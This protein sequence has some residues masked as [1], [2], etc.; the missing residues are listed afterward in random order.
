MLIGLIRTI[1]III[2]IYYLV[3]FLMWLFRSPATTGS[4]GKSQD[5]HQK[6]K[7]GEVTID[8]TPDNKKQIRKDSGDYVDFE[9]VKDD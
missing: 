4:P 5:P 6:G 2:G 8:F 3:K 1:L 9:E 7:E